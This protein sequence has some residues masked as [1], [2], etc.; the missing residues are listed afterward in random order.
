MGYVL[1]ALAVSDLCVSAIADSPPEEVV[2]A[3]EPDVPA[4]ARYVMAPLAEI[5]QFEDQSARP[6]TQGVSETRT[7]IPS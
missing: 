1:G 4:R 7:Q 3:Y 5:G 6:V 2:W